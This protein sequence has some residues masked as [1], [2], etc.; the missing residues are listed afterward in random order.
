MLVL[1][2]MSFQV[3]VLER[4]VVAEVPTVKMSLR[5]KAVFNSWSTCSPSSLAG[6]KALLDVL[7]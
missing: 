6:R 7:A 1:W 3:M 2:W 5:L 4:P